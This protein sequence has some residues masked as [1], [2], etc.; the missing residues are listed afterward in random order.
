M[1]A[2]QKIHGN[3]VDVTSLIKNFTFFPK[4]CPKYWNPETVYPFHLGTKERYPLSITGH[5]QVS[6]KMDI[7]LLNVYK[8]GFKDRKYLACYGL[9]Y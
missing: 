1:N 6:S 3:P 7:F 8:H 4:I 9:N 2:V 5:S